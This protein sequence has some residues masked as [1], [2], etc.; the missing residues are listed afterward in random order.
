MEWAHY[1][2][3]CDVDCSSCYKVITALCLNMQNL[4][5]VPWGHPLVVGRGRKVR[6][7]GLFG[8]GYKNRCIYAVGGESPTVFKPSESAF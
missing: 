1:A 2:H 8:R 3:G 5:V 7:R 4:A 6:I